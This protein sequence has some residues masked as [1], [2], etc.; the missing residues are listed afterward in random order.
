MYAQTCGYTLGMISYHFDEFI[1]TIQVSALDLLTYFA[2][3]RRPTLFSG[4][5]RS[6]NR[7]IVLTASCWAWSRVGT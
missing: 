3:V 7:H 6:L 4:L 5:E 1:H 2:K